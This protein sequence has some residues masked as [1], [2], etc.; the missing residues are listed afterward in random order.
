MKKRSN[1]IK[2]H[3]PRTLQKRELEMISGGSS[4]VKADRDTLLPPP[5]PDVNRN[6]K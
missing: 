2:Q 5:S 1:G 6:L 3:A 4:E